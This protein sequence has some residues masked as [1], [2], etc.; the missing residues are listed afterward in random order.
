MAAFSAG[1]EAWISQLGDLRNVI[2]QE[3]I[4]RQLAPF[5]R[6]GLRV[7]DVGSGQGTQAV[8]LARLGC[9]VTCLEPAEELR[10]LCAQAAETGGVQ[11]TQIAGSVHDAPTL[12]S[13]EHFDIVCAHGVLMY[14]DDRAEALA[15]LAERVAP[16]GLLSIAF[17][18]GDALAARPGMRRDWNGVIAAMAA[19][20]YVNGLG[21]TARS[22][23]LSDVEHDLRSAGMTP[24]EWFGV[25][26]FNDAVP[27]GSPLPADEDLNALLDAE[28]MAGRRDPYRWFGSLIHHVSVR[29]ADGS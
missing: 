9:H 29:S 16:R 4:R 8:H 27:H 26:V 7:L 2:R 23:R 1:Q 25:R 19:D 11:V 3:L 15:T 20:Q 18:N 12:L 17:R 5:A 10:R 28:E 21:V 22:D 6:P 13:G 24:M 14:L